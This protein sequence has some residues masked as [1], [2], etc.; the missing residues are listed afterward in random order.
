MAQI[1]AGKGLKKTATRDSSAVKGGGGVLDAASGGTPKANISAPK[2]DESAPDLKQFKNQLAGLF[3]GPPAPKAPPPKAPAAEP[4]AADPASAP[5]PP[6]P[7]A[8][9]PPPPVAAPPP[10]PPPPPPAAAPP[11]PPPVASPPPPPPLSPPPLAPPPLAPP[12]LAPPPLTPPP[13]AP[14]GANGAA[15]PPPPTPPL[16]QSMST[17]DAAGEGA[18]A[19]ADKEARRKKRLS[20]GRLTGREQ[21]KKWVQANQASAGAQG[22][23]E[24]YGVLEAV[25]EPTPYDAESLEPRTGSSV[26]GRRLTRAR[27]TVAQLPLCGERDGERE[28]DA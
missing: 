6:P 24:V 17:P 12:P 3:G 19:A 9:P 1:Q 2:A 15:V 23:A 22:G 18:Q 11:P 25:E 13:L 16:D 21:Q 10:P 4:A 14:P 5:P 8:A 20:S 7:V 28:H 26:P 27:R